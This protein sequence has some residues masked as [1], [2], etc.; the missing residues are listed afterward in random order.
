M[1]SNCSKTEAMT[2]PESFPSPGKITK[3]RKCSVSSLNKEILLRVLIVLRDSFKNSISNLLTQQLVSLIQD[4]QHVVRS[5]KGTVTL[6]M[7]RTKKFSWST[8][9]SLTIIPR[10]KTNICQM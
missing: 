5:T 3:S 7:T 2:V 8:M 9:E 4:G 6:T 10:S 1:G